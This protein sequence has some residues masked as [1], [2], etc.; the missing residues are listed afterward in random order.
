MHAAA[1]TPRPSRHKNKH[2]DKACVGAQVYPNG[3]VSAPCGGK[4]GTCC[5]GW[6]CKIDGEVSV[7]LGDKSNNFITSTNAPYADSTAK[8]DQCCLSQEDLDVTSLFCPPDALA[9]GVCK[10]D[11]LPA[12]LPF[13]ISEAGVVSFLNNAA[14]A[15]C[16]GIIRIDFG[17]DSLTDATTFTLT[18]N[19]N[20]ITASTTVQQGTCVNA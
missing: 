16:L 8:V 5:K 15:C 18:C 2:E 3:F 9:Y 10:I 6:T 4:R 13:D 7:K 1:G 19:G 17:E 12:E 14:C 11:E 20:D